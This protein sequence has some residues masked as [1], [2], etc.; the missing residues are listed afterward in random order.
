MRLGT[1]GDLVCLKVDSG[2]LV[3]Q[4]NLSTDFGGKLMSVW[5]YSESPLVDGDRVICTP[6]GDEAAMVALNKVTGDLMWKCALPSLGDLGRRRAGYSSAVVAN[7]DGVRQY[8]QLT[9][10]GVIGVEAA[11]GRFLWG[12]NQIANN[13]ANIPT[14][15]VHGQYVFVSTAYSTG[16]AL[17]KIVRDGQA[18]RRK[19]FTF[20]VPKIFKTTTVAW[21]WSIIMCMAEVA[22]IRG[23][24]HASI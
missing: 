18:W 16:S 7:I 11:T 14:P 24:Q 6:G 21:C 5:K 3:W 20:S 10:R 13:V 22:R 17:L 2:E 9:G 19:R 8:I 1:E 15:I 4:R 23:F 12:Y